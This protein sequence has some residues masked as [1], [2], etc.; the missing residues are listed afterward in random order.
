MADPPDEVLVTRELSQVD[1]RP[2]PVLDALGEDGLVQALGQATRMRSA[3]KR[4]DPLRHRVRRRLAGRAA[5]PA[6]DERERVPLLAAERGRLVYQ[7]GDVGI[8]AGLKADCR[9][10]AAVAGLVVL[11]WGGRRWPRA[12]RPRRGG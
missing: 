11:V 10:A 2:V 4:I 1:I 5:R 7:P 9:V 3:M 8:Q 12:G 6:Q